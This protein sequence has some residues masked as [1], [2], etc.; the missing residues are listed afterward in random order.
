VGANAIILEELKEP[1][2]LAKVADAVLGVP[3]ERKGQVLAIFFRPP[4]E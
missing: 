3:A 2:D 1:G 4:E